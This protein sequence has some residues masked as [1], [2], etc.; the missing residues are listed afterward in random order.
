LDRLDLQNQIFDDDIRLER[1]I[2]ARGIPVIVT[3]Q[4]SIHG[5]MAGSA[6]IDLMMG[7]K[8]YEKLADGAFC[9][10][11]G[12]LIFDL[13]PRNVIQVE[14]GEIFPIDPVVQR[15]TAEFGDFLRNHPD[16]INR[17]Y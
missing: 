8:N 1:I 5:V 12:L 7:S 4:P 16:T 14:T 13:F 10:G 6:A 3:S 17:D 15:I 9:N 11:N 2:D